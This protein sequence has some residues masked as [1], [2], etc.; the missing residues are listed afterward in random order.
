MMAPQGTPAEAYPA[1]RNFRTAQQPLDD[2]SGG[3]ALD[4]VRARVLRMHRRVVD[5]LPGRFTLGSR[6]TIYV[7]VADRSD[8]SPELIVI[9]G[10]EQCDRGV[11]QGYYEKC[12][13]PR[14]GRSNSSASR[15]RFDGVADDRRVD[16]TSTIIERF[17]SAA[18]N[19]SHLSSR[20]IP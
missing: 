3:P 12:H 1:S 14:A 6:V 7:A 15:S 20:H 4:A 19:V 11:C 2:G 17:R 10:V 16:L 9:L 13:E 8:R 5:W 18:A